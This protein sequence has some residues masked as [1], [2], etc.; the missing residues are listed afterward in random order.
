MS[1]GPNMPS[2]W[3]VAQGGSQNV[4][5]QVLGWLGIFVR[6]CCMAKDYLAFLVFSKST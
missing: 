1:P 5:G 6:L 2:P 3:D 4:L